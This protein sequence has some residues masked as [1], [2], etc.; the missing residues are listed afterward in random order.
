MVTT[1]CRFPCGVVV[2]C[3]VS[4]AKMDGATFSDDFLV[5][6]YYI[7]DMV[8][9]EFHHETDVVSYCM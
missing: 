7:C 8:M 3:R 9:L 4:C 2:V 1:L 5:D 6:I